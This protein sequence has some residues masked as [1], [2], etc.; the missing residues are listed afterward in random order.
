[1]KRVCVILL[2]LLAF[3]GSA[4][5]QF[6]SMGADPGGRRWSS[7]LTPTY[8]LI[9]PRGLDSLAR[10]YAVALEQAA[11]P[12]G[13]S[14]GFRPNEA[15]RTRMPVVLHTASAQSNGQVTWTPRRLELLTT[16]DAFA[17][18]STP[19][20]VILA[21]HESRHVAQMQ[22]GGAKPF[23]WLRVLGGELAA[24]GL[25]AVYGGPA[26]LEGDAVV[27]ETA[28]TAAGRG[29]TAEFLEYFRV[30]FA[31]GDYRDYWRWRYGSQRYY[32]PDYYRAGYLAIGGIRALYDVP[33]LS[34]RFYR[35]IA[36][37]GGVA[38]F[39]WNKTVREATGL[40]FRDAFSA[41]CDSLQQSWV[42][43]E[44]ARGPFLP[45][46]A[47]SAT[48][49]Y[50]TEYRSLTGAGDGFYAVRSGLTRPNQLVWF[51][52][53]GREKTV[54]LMGSG[55]S[56]PRFSSAARRLF[57]SETVSDVRWPLR[58]WSVIRSFDGTKQKTITRRTRYYHPVPEP[59]APRLAVTEYPEDGSSRVVLLDMDNG[60]ELRH[61]TAPDGMQVVETAW[62]GGEL[63]ASAITREGMGLYRVA[64]FSPVLALRPLSITQLWAS[65]GRL[66]FTS[67]LSGVNEL[68]S[69]DLRTGAAQRMTTTR[70]G[71]TD[72]EI[73]RDTLFYSALQPEGRLVQGTAL[74]DLRPQ[75]ADF[76]KLVRYPFAEELAAGEPAQPDWQASVEVSEPKPYSK[77][78]HLFH[79]HSWL[80]VY[81]K[82]DDIDDLSLESIQQNAGL[83]A[84]AFFQN[85]LGSSW[86]Q[87]GY[88]AD[89]SKAGWRHSAHASFTYT[90]LY[91]V[92]EAGLDV[93]DREAW[94]YWVKKE[95]NRLSFEHDSRGVT[96]VSGHVRA[97][98][99]WTFNSGG[100]LRGLIP[101]AY[102]ALTNDRDETGASM[103]RS[104]FSLRG[105]MMQRTPASRM[106]PRFG[107]GAEVGWGMRWTTKYIAP[108]SYTYLY[109]YLPGL[110]ETHS[111]RWTA[112]LAQRLDGGT[113]SESLARTAPRGFESA[114]SGRMASSSEQF[115]GSVDYV[116]PIFSV[117]RAVLGPAAY[118]RNFELTLHGD[119]SSFRSPTQSGNLYSVGADLVA[120]LGNL[121]W[122]PYPTRIGVSYNY[123]G[124]SA[125]QTFADQ[126]LPV[127][128]HDVSLVFRIEM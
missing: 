124:G 105:Y 111:L 12:V 92:I 1:M 51:G 24:G 5:A 60:R 118:L 106:Y 16:P 45:A 41:V 14:L 30:S 125:Y 71:A 29:R 42:A 46:T 13:A 52:A 101:T 11:T 78:A 108:A 91:P 128:R 127:K 15:Y 95:N 100:W 22:A 33:D 31:A 3:W 126:E 90:G 34:A 47:V 79:V 7:V 32:T 4:R 9:Y 40:S 53:D 44:A 8:Q 62:A 96:S 35:R 36:D 21:V 122:I 113:F 107:I 80:P 115:K 77:L 49:R 19:W 67:D 86:G 94:R 6:Y 28:L 82:Y 110:Y 73:L 74:S 93:G 38:L 25:C 43:D 50:F 2:L 89:P 65:E 63:Y 70:F 83:G 112:V 18:D 123:N 87:V 66:L 58:S 121:L 84:T 116:M 27:A 109:G 119:W 75:A 99:P 69:L 37:H 97:Y 76:S 17:F 81:F 10:V 103:Q 39:N 57:W 61:W 59:D 64:D 88:H 117:D 48:P 55:L 85:A 26:F 104:I 54:A 98:I 102:F 68:Y 23:C 120:V 72:F 20:P 56:H 114:I